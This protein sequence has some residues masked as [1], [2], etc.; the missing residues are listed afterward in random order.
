V[1][2]LRSE[3]E[4]LNELKANLL[5]SP[6]DP[7]IETEIGRWMLDHGHDEEGR[8]SAEEVIRSHPEH[9]LA[10]H[11]LVVYH[12]RRGEVGLANFYRLKT[13]EETEPSDETASDPFE[14]LD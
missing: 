2:R 12:R 8:R 13:R 11:L 10:N 3:H 1:K 9:P 7:D 4:R 6:G 5:R 14:K